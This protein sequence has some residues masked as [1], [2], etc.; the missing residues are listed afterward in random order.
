MTISCVVRTEITLRHH[1]T[2]TIE[3]TLV[4]LLLL[5][6]FNHTLLYN[7]VALVHT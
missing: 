3:T 7:K 4:P 5:V 2:C 6:G 1:S